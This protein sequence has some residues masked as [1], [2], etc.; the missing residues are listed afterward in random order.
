MGDEGEGE[1]ADDNFG[2]SAMEV[3]EE[4]VKKSTGRG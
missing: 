1:H 2:R 3:T 4:K